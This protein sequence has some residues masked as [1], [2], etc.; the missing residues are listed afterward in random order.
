MREKLEE[1]ESS[2]VSGEAAPSGE[3]GAAALGDTALQHQQLGASLAADA[4]LQRQLAAHSPEA[5]SASAAAEAQRI[6][7]T[8]RAKLEES[9]AAEQ[10]EGGEEEQVQSGGGTEASTPPGAAAGAGQQRQEQ[11]QQQQLRE[12]R[13]ASP[14]EGSPPDAAAAAS[15]G[16]GES[17]QQRSMERSQEPRP[18]PVWSGAHGQQLASLIEGCVHSL[19]LL[20]QGAGANGGLPP[21]ALGAALDAALASVAPKEAA[22]AA[23]FEEV[24]AAMAGLKLQI[25]AVAM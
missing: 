8:C 11:Q 10:D 6:I 9:A 18:A 15:S 1:L 14:A 4:A 13:G 16:G 22:N 5:L 21:R 2:G 25:G 12:Q 3:R 23:L 24:K 20:Q 17:A 7:S 19:V